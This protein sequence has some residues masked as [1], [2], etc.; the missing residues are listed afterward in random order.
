MGVITLQIAAELNSPPARKFLKIYLPLDYNELYAL[1]LADFTNVFVDVDGDALENVKITVLPLSGN[2]LVSGLAA[3]VN[4]VITSAQLGLGVLTYQADPL[5]T[6]G[7][8]ANFYYT[9]SD[10][11]SST[12]SANGGSVFITVDEQVN[13]APTEVGDGT[14]T[15]AYGETG[16][17][18][19]VMFT[20]GTSPAYA[21]PEGDPALWLKITGLPLLGTIQLNS[22]S[23]G[24]NQVVDFN[25]IDLGLLTY[26]PDLADNDGDMQGFTFEIAVFG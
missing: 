22:I 14:M 26:V 3:N 8:N 17:F 6:L 2:L 23:I 13:L 11:G 16:I 4:D 9:A 21:D 5:E 20:T 19:R 10:V 18:T 7:Y 1:T 12:Y 25:D 24:I 15:L